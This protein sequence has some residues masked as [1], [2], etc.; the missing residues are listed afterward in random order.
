M[1]VQAL[2]VFSLVSYLGNVTVDHDSDVPPYLQLAAILRDRILSG[3]IPP[4]RPLPSMTTLQQE[5]GLARGT[6]RKAV[7]VLAAE[8]LV[9]IRPG[10]GTFVVPEA[11]LPRT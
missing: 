8:G 2:S 4:R 7:G 3:E 5:H 11:D 1:P 10:W 6:I 9:R